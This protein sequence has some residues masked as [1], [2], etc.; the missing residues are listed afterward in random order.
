MKE[1]CYTEEHYAGT[2]GDVLLGKQTGR[3]SDEEIT[4][5]EALGMAVEDIACAIYLYEQAKGG[6][7]R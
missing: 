6:S 4:V 2:L 1:G 3:T 7:D 5:F